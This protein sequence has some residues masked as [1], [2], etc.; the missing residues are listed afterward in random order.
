MRVWLKKRLKLY[1]L[2][3]TS[4]LLYLLFIR[5][6]VIHDT[7]ESDQHGGQVKLVKSSQRVD[8]GISMSGNVL[9]RTISRLQREHR[10]VKRLKSTGIDNIDIVNR[11]FTRLTELSDVFISVKTTVQNHESRLN[12]L[13]DTWI[14]TALNQ[15]NY[16]CLLD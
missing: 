15:V 16:G 2:L 6:S 1:L 5:K 12:L 7:A 9:H 8:N 3:M 10:S 4:I 14:R 13:L 11:T